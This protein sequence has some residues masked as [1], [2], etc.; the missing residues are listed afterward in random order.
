MC[1]QVLESFG[2]GLSSVLLTP[3]GGTLSCNLVT[4]FLFFNTSTLFIALVQQLVGSTFWNLVI[5]KASC[6]V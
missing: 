3:S 2:D 5:F 4:C 6:L 1:W